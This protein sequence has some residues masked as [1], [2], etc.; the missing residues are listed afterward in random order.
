MSFFSPD[1][2][3]PV[4]LNLTAD[5]AQREALGRTLGLVGTGVGLAGAIMV[6]MSNPAVKAAL[7]KGK[8]VDLTVSPEQAKR[9]ALGKSLALFG[10][11][12]GMTGTT[13]S[14]TANPKVWGKMPEFLRARP[15]LVTGVLGTA[16]VA[17]A[18]LM[19]KAQ[20]KAFLG[21]RY[22]KG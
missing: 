3:A 6:L 5:E 10:L 7:A 21:T 18:V 2:T 19:V 20:N 14:M 22:A 15:M 8:A 16:L 13:L 11:A 17:G 12:V 1:I 4:K 9:E